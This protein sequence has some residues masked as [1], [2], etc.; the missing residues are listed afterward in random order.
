MIKL[1]IKNA[2]LSTPISSDED[3]S[4]LN[5]HFRIGFLLIH[6]CILPVRPTGKGLYIVQLQKTEA[7]KGARFTVLFK[8]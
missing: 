2:F 7:N 6:Q 3:V 4:C 8:K 5:I 1:L